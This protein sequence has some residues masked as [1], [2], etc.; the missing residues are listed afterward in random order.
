M[1]MDAV[2]KCH[3]GVEYV[4][5]VLNQLVNKI[6]LGNLVYRRRGALGMKQRELAAA[7]EKDQAWVSKLER[8]NLGYLP[9]PETLQLLATTLGITQIELL[10]AWGYLQDLNGHSGDTDSKAKDDFS[11]M[12]DDIKIFFANYYDQMSPEMRRILNAQIR[13]YRDELADIRRMEGDG[14]IESNR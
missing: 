10:Q 1:S 13:V 9:E 14:D 2:S 4:N 5:I 3:S 8:D 12:P 6:T 11:E 7:V